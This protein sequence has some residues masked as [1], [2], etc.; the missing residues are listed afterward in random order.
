M[1]AGRGAGL[2]ADVADGLQ[3]HAV[4]AEQVGHVLRPLDPDADEADA[5]RLDRLRAARRRLARGRSPGRPP[6]PAQ[7]HRGPEAGAEPQEV[8]PAALRVHGMYPGLEGESRA[9]RLIL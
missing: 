2:L 7:R 5:D 6:R 4:D 8:S 1:R 3:L 9:K